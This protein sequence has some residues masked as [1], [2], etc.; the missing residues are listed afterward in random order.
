MAILGNNEKM[1]KVNNLFISSWEL[2]YPIKASLLSRWFSFSQGGI[3]DPFPGKG[4]GFFAKDD[5]RWG[6]TA[7]K[8][9]P[10]VW[11]QIANK[12]LVHPQRKGLSFNHPFSGGIPSLELTANAPKI[13][14][15]GWNTTSR[16]LLGLGLFSGA[17]ADSFREG[18]LRLQLWNFFWV[19]SIYPSSS[20]S[21]K[22]RFTPRKFKIAPEN[23]W[24]ED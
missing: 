6:L 15:F 16:F 2:T 14:G 8:I 1:H 4:K 20:N 3:C 13:L 17:F 5:L 22:W 12:K 21:H 24:L 11:T 7:E 9:T 19:Y 10:E 23:W 18:S